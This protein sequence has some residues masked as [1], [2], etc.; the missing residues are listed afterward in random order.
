MLT[1]GVK[2]PMRNGVTIPVKVEVVLTND[3]SEPAK[4]GAKSKALT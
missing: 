4:F 3:V 1:L 2:R